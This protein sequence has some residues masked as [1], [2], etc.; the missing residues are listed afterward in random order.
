M[1]KIHDVALLVGSL[2]KDSINRKVANALIELAPAGLNKCPRIPLPHPARRTAS[3]RRSRP[4]RRG[5]SGRVSL[6]VPLQAG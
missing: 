6:V 3:L 5:S 4:G 2:R 1:D